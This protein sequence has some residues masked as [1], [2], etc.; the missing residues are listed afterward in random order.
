VHLTYH[1][2]VTASVWNTPWPWLGLLV[3]ALLVVV[4]PLLYLGFEPPSYVGRRRAGED[5]LPVDHG[6]HVVGWPARD[7]RLI[8]EDTGEWAID[9]LTDALWDIE[10]ALDLVERELVAG[11]VR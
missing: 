4:V 5:G 11:G 3:L 2:G 10:V 6:R 1:V 9:D 8:V 7:V